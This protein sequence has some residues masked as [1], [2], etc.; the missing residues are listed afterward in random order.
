MD[1]VKVGMHTEI[2]MVGKTVLS[3]LDL[4]EEYVMT[5]PS[6]YGRS[7]LTVPQFEIGGQVA[8]TCAKTGY[9]DNLSL[10]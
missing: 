10:S 4:D 1:Q 5:F 7:I 8:I 3:L 2:H 9:S 6:A